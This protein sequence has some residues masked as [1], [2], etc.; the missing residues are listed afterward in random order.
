MHLPVVPWVMFWKKC[1]LL[2][3]RSLR[4]NFNVKKIKATF[5]PM[6]R[7]DNASGKRPQDFFHMKTS[8]CLGYFTLKQQSHQKHFI[9]ITGKPTRSTF[10]GKTKPFWII[11]HTRTPS[12][13]FNLW[14]PIFSGFYRKAELIFHR[15]DCPFPF[16]I[17]KYKRWKTNEGWKREEE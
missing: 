14:P 6:P 11:F 1:S 16:S 15:V 7:G 2:D 12:P 3:F 13:H 10:S 9:K 4:N 8:T 17:Y 5:F